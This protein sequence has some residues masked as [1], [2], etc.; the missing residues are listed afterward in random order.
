[1]SGYILSMLLHS[2]ICLF[3]FIAPLLLSTM[4]NRQSPQNPTARGFICGHGNG[5]CQ[6]RF[7]RKGDLD[8]HIKACHR[9]NIP[10]CPWC[11]YENARPYR[12]WDHMENT[13]PKQDKGLLLNFSIPIVVTSTDSVRVKILQSPL[14]INNISNMN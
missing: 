11:K 12:M 5:S 7:K 9:V 14:K 2:S 13:H 10:K 6:S 3:K 4:A 8:R 1:V